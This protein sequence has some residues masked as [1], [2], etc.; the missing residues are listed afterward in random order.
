MLSLTP[1]INFVVGRSL[2][3]YTNTYHVP[4]SYCLEDKV[5]FIYEVSFAVG[6]E[7]GADPR[8]K[9]AGQDVDG[10][11]KTNM[12]DKSDKESPRMNV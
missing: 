10:I 9:C 8:K 2:I 1:I 11:S 7:S 6:K 12:D 4:F 5:A 3:V